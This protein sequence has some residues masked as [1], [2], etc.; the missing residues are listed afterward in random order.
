MPV[1]CL[2]LNRSVFSTVMIAVCE[3]VQWQVSVGSSW[4]GRGEPRRRGRG[5]RWPRGG[6]R[7]RRSRRAA[8][9]LAP[10]PDRSRHP[11]RDRSETRAPPRYP[12]PRP[13]PAER[14]RRRRRRPEPRRRRLARPPAGSSPRPRRVSPSRGGACLERTRERWVRGRGDPMDLDGGKGSGAARWMESNKKNNDVME[15]M[16]NSDGNGKANNS[17]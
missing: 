7:P 9:P 4:L 6:P 13:N 11:S 12:P 15:N 10:R 5:G 2:E 8:P 14:D 16:E 17:L 1:C 3:S